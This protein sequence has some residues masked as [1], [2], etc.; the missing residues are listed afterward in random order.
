MSRLT[1]AD[2]IRIIR[3]EGRSV[4]HGERIISSLD[5]LPSEIELAHG[6]PAAEKRA[7][8]NLVKMKAHL[9]QQIADL[10]NRHVS[11]TEPDGIPA[12]KTAPGSEPTISTENKLNELRAICKSLG[13][14]ADGTKE[15]LV[16][17]I[18]NVPVN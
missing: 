12:E 15:Q 7:L 2:M 6:D 14:P 3:D 5:E 17:R 13:L 4:I 8:E 18:Q 9:D 10:A 16:A 11:T 1:H